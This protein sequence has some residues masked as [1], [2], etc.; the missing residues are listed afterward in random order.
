MSEW[1]LYTELITIGGWTNKCYVNVETNEKI[2]VDN[3]GDIQTY[4][5]DKKEWVPRPPKTKS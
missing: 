5:E 3:Y 1:L 4:D 2:L